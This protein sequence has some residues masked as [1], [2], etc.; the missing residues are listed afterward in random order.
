MTAP[1]SAANGGAD[2]DAEPAHVEDVRH[3]QEEHQAE[4]GD[5]P[6]SRR[7]CSGP[8]LVVLLR[9]DVEPA[10]AAAAP[11]RPRG[12]GTAASAPRSPHQHHRRRSR[13]AR[14]PAP[15]PCSRRAGRPWSGSG[16]TAIRLAELPVIVIDD[17]TEMQ[18]Q[19]EQHQVLA[20]GVVASPRSSRRWRRPRSSAAASSRARGRGRNQRGQHHLEDQEGQQRPGGLVA[21]AEH[22]P[23]APCAWRA[24]SSPAWSSG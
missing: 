14:R 7:G 24:A 17:S 16:P 22:Q 8:M 19:V 13:P 18:H 11:A 4:D 20:E 21:E 23:R 5:A 9:D 6:S 15:S 3:P 2:L 1:S 10:F 12:C